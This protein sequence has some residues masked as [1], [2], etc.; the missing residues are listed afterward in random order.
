M[1]KV[2]IV[3][4]EPLARLG[5]RESIDWSDY[6]FEIAGDAEDAASAVE[7]YRKLKPDVVITDIC[8]E[9]VDGLTLIED[10]QAYNK[11]LEFIVISGYS[12]F[13][14][15]Q[16]AMKYGVST[17]ILKPIENEDLTAALATLKDKLDHKR[18]T[19]KIVEEYTDRQK[20]AYL[21]EL[22]TCDDRIEQVHEQLCM[23]GFHFPQ[24]KNYVVVNMKID[25][26][27]KESE[28]Q[29]HFVALLQKLAKNCFT[30]DQHPILS[31]TLRNNHVILIL[32]EDKQDKKLPEHLIQGIINE[33]TRE[34]DKHVT[35]GISSIMSKVSLLPRAFTQS[36]KALKSTGLPAGNKVIHYTAKL[37]QPTQQQMPVF[38]RRQNEEL[39]EAI[40]LSDRKA[41]TGIIDSYFNQ[42]RALHAVDLDEIKNT[43]I[44]LTVYIN[45]HYIRTPEMMQMIFNRIVHPAKEVW[46]M[47][48]IEEIYDWLMSLIDTLMNNKQVKGFQTYSPLI[49]NAITYIMSNYAKDC[50]INRAAKHLYVSAGHLMRQFKQ[51]TGK[52]FLEYLTEYRISLS[53]TLLQS[54]NY[55]IYEVGEMVGYGNTKYFRKIF[56]RITGKSP[57]EFMN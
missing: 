28:P 52:T 30:T 36:E 23:E 7:L 1:Y 38:S 3:D 2:L 47:E 9:P 29:K 31:T 40:I 17:Y 8:M 25:N 16:R 43:I 44:N 32:F 14:Y 5:L 20:E 11:D 21:A 6:G 19:K 24:N 42:I 33:F 48:S 12:D 56:M 18:K 57:K 22:L 15:A 37:D 27:S 51:E 50:D 10:L 41:V 35:A 55:K 13:Q 54:R 26:L 45:L 39:I 53:I 46:D 34:T 4:D 49:Q